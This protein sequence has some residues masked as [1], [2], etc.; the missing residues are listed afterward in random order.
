VWGPGSSGLEGLSQPWGSV[1]WG[2]AQAVERG[3]WGVRPVWLSP[4]LLGCFG[5]SR[6]ARCWSLLRRWD[7]GRDAW[8]R[9]VGGAGRG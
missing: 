7:G 9:E 5:G 3:A 6:G 1:G 2:R 4:R 8:S